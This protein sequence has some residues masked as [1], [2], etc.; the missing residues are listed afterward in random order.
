MKAYFKLVT[1][2]HVFVYTLD[3]QSW[4]CEHVVI[5]PPMLQRSI[6]DIKMLR[7]HI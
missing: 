5:G 4:K 7:S 2:L 3:I 6:L 1:K